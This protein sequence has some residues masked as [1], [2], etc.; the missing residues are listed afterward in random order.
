MTTKPPP[1]KGTVGS[2][3]LVQLRSQVTALSRELEVLQERLPGLGRLSTGSAVLSVEDLLLS[4]EE[5]QEAA[6][7]TLWLAHYWGLAQSL[8]NIPQ[9]AT[10][11]AERWASAAPPEEALH[12]AAADV[13]ERVRLRSQG[14]STNQEHT[15]AR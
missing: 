7:R 6:L 15:P 5:V 14:V 2:Q 3:E 4:A 10:G 12:A 8:G 13:A 1:T 11:Q 9:L